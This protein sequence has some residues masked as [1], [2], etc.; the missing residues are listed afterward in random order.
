MMKR[1]MMITA[2]FL[3]VVAAAAQTAHGTA[4][5]KLCHALSSSCV[6][7]KCTYSIN[8][9][10]TRVAGDADVSVQGDMY[11][12]AGN[13]LQVYCDGSKVWSVDSA[14]KEVYV[15]SVDALDANTLANPAALFMHLGT[16]FNLIS[17]S[18]SGGNF[19]YRL[20]SKTACG[21]KSA[22]LELDKDG[23]PI[24]AAF[25]L[26]DGLKVDVAIKTMAIEKT[27]PEDVF[28][29]QVSFG[30]DWIVTEL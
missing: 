12:M 4:L 1:I 21:V 26:E 23:K 13:G 30:S 2:A 27:K 24:S 6:T 5:E 3:S 15:E 18:Q 28:R 22:D 17:S 19:L 20:A 29:P 7:M 11:T 9:S 16:S 25:V 10:N 8:I 14:A